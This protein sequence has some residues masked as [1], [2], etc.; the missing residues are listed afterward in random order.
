M[1]VL[2]GQ[3][4]G[5]TFSMATAD[6]DAVQLAAVRVDG[7]VDQELDD[8]S[9]RAARRGVTACWSPLWANPLL[10]GNVADAGWPWRRVFDPVTR[11][12]GTVDPVAGCL[13]GLVSS[14]RG[15]LLEGLLRVSYGWRSVG[16]TKAQPSRG[17]PP[18]NP[19]V[20][21][22]ETLAGAPWNRADFPGCAPRIPGI[23]RALLGL[24]VLL[25]KETNTRGRLALHP[26]PGRI[27][28]YRAC[29]PN[30]LLFTDG[31]E[32]GLRPDAGQP[33]APYLEVPESDGNDYLMTGMPGGG[34]TPDVL[35]KSWP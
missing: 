29:F 8:L 22:V 12:P 18:V 6:G 16:L 5:R 28:W 11:F 27:T 35:E 1:R 20:L 9:L 26:A 24:S 19:P 30:C 21:Y 14:R 2:P 3:T 34:P 25:S 10:S 33:D 31:R 15:L 32:F 17:R 4:L 7:S 13:V 23:G